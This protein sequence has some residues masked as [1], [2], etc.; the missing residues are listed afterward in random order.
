MFFSLYTHR[1]HC[2]KTERKN[3]E[4]L[5]LMKVFLLELFLDPITLFYSFCFSTYFVCARAR[6]IIKKETEIFSEKLLAPCP[7][8]S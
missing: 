5:E 4:K 6:N 8:S 3:E 7:L 2:A 1:W